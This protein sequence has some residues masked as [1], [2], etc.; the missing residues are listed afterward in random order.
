MKHPLLLLWSKSTL[1]LALTT[2]LPIWFPQFY[3]LSQVSISSHFILLGLSPKLGK[4]T[5]K[6]KK[7]LDSS[8]PSLYII[9]SWIPHYLLSK[10]FLYMFYGQKCLRGMPEWLSSS[11]C[12]LGPLEMSPK[13][14]SLPPFM[15]LPFSLH[16]SWMNK[17]KS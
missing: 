17:W 14:G 16:L 7:K 4:T 12:D 3:S 11:G 15:S 8:Q 1:F 5:K 13:L 10:K 9:F 2:F 6:K